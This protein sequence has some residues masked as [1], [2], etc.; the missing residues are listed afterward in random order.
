MPDNNET[1]TRFKVDISELRSA[2][3]DAKRQISVTN[4]EFKAISSTMEDWSRSSTGISAKLNQLN[5][6]LTSQRT[7]LSSL[8]RQYELT[9]QEM[10]EGSAEADR[11]KIAVNNQRAVVNDTEREIVRWGN[12]LDE[13]GQT[14]A[15]TGERADDLGDDIDDLEKSTKD[16]SKGFTVFKGV[17]ANLATAGIMAV[18]NGCKQAVGALVGMVK[19]SVQAYAEYEQ[20]VGGVDTLFKDSSK[21]VQKYANDAYKTAGMN[22][23]RYMDTVTSFSASLLSALHG[24]TAKSAKVADMAIIDMSDN[25]NKMGTSIEMIQNAYQGFAKQNY[26]MLDNLKLG[27]GGTKEEMQRLLKDASKLSGQKYDISNL[28]DVFQAIHVVQTELGIT[29]TTAKEASTTIEGSVNS[30][31]AAWQNL[32]A[33]MANENADFGQLVDNLVDSVTTMLGNVMPR[34]TQALSGVVQLLGGL[35]PIISEQLPKLLDGILPTLLE[36]LGALGQA[37]LQALISSAPT[38]LKAVLDL[39]TTIVNALPSVLNQIMSA[40]G[41]LLPQLINGIGQ[42][43]HQILNS[44]I[45][46]IYEIISGIVAM[47]PKILQAGIKLFI[48]LAEA[49]PSITDNLLDA[50]VNLLDQIVTALI[51]SIPQLLDSA[52]Q[53]FTAIVDAIPQ[54]V[55]QIKVYLPLIIQSITDYLINAVPLLMH[56]A[57]TLFN[58]IVQ[59]IP[60]IL[61]VLTSALPQILTAIVSTLIHAIPVLLQGA[62]QLLMA[63]I[64][65]I[66]V[67]ITALVEALPRIIEAI[68]TALIENIPLLLDTAVQVFM[69]LVQAIPKIVVALAKALPQ[70]IKA[71]VTAV[72]TLIPKLFQFTGELIK[73]VVEWAGRIGEKGKNGAKTFVKNVVDFIKKLPSDVAEH[74]TKVITKVA[75]FVASFG[76]KAIEAGKTFVTNVINFIKNLPS[77]VWTWLSNTLTKLSSFVS[78]MK[79]KATEAA[80]GFLTNIVNGIKG[81]PDKV[82]D[83]GTNIV[84]GLWNGIG[85][86]TSWIKDKIKGFGSSVVNGLKDFFRIRS[87]SRLTRDEVGKYIALGVAEGIEKNKKYAK[88]SASEMGEAILTSAKKKVKLLEGANKISLKQEIDYWKEIMKHTKKGSA[89]YLEATAEMNNAKEKYQKNIISDSKKELKLLQS[90]N[91]ISL[92]G[93]VDYWE[94]VRKQTKKG[95]DAYKTAT[96]EMNKA[97]TALNKK[98]TALDKKFKEDSQKVYT[99]LIKEITE[100][101][102]KYQE[103]VDSRAKSITSSLDLFKKFEASEVIGKTDLKANLKSQVDALKD[104]DNTLTK[105]SKRKGMDSGLLDELEGMGVDSLE[106]LKELNNMSDKELAEYIKLYKEKNK[107]AKDRAVKENADLLADTQNQIKK[108]QDEAKTKLAALKTTYDKELAALGMAVLNNGSGIGQ[109]I[110]N[111][112]TKGIKSSKKTL[113]TTLKNL[114]DSLVKDVK[115]ALKIKSVSRVLADEVGKFIPSGIAMGIEKNAKAVYSSMKDLTANTVRSTRDG[116]TTGGAT[117][118]VV[119]NYTQ[120]INSPKQLSRLD[121]YRQSKNLLGFVGGGY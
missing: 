69:A 42:A 108:L 33:G 35:A 2:M 59:A 28:N 105:L 120:V 32:L 9:V 37:I 57:I 118:G 74:L 97:K 6:N 39:V 43:L 31:K 18:A 47:T 54:I 100:L 66:P 75:S 1:T 117:G 45:S 85:N 99:E 68:I 87:P 107:I 113:N 98:L 91:K 21:T 116:L 114:A 92:A 29:G 104:W 38:L 12:A 23:N 84:K 80:K 34:V 11:L 61:P 4:S 27:Y 86:M 20:L 95:S 115:K 17:M 111:G 101:N 44:I 40:L 30:M 121:I 82:K 110:V 50:V 83:I 77:N 119:N 67:I 76:A 102:K 53:F 112:I 58:A 46:G 65:A 49:L 36:S 81:I 14:E 72:F 52:V 16:A 70:I 71:I 78:S 89:A 103:A 51:N 48:G 7:I 19:E 13:V 93:E 73:K 24:D 26:T 15:D 88:K 79:S 64:D 3:Q 90:S 8:E 109:N 60:Q 55:E 22:A 63:L 10:G 5:S 94:N 96:T 56:G 41:E 25:A 106:T 62:I